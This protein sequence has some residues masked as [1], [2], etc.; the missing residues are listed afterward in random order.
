MKEIELE[1][2]DDLYID[3][4]IGLLDSSYGRNLNSNNG[5]YILFS[6]SDMSDYILVFNMEFF[7]NLTPRR[8]TGKS[9]PFVHNGFK[10]FK[11]KPNNSDFA[12]ELI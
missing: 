2:I 6:F 10:Q 9:I 8:G 4:D 3:N 7:V 1:S 12:K 5:R 11:E